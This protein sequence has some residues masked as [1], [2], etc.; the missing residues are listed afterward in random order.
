MIERIIA[1]DVGGTNIKYGIVAG[2]VVQTFS[3]EPTYPE[4]GKDQLL[5]KLKGI[6]KKYSKVSA[7]VGLGIAGLVDHERGVV[8]NPPN[9]PGWDEVD[10]KRILESS[11]NVRCFVVNDANAYALGEWQFGSGR[12]FEDVIAITLGTGVGGGI[13]TGGRL[14][15]GAMNF[16]GEIGHMVIDPSGPVCN[17]G[18]RGC[19]EAFLGNGYFSQR[20]RAYFQR[21]GQKLDDYSPHI[22]AELA[23]NGNKSAAFL[24][25]EYGT[26]LGIGLV[27]L[28]HL[29]DPDVI[30][31][32]G[33]ISGAFDLFIDSCLQ[34][35]R[36]RVM[37]F[38]RRKLKIEKASLGSNASLLGAYYF[39]LMEGNVS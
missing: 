13:I 2:G 14:I 23:R 1:I 6:I 33:G 28:I 8:Y 25:Q 34:I 10:V 24:W 3:S 27:N 11:T 29:F 38:E 20:A 16:A 31:L 26:F 5:E 21:Q 36:S 32:G 35:L 7:R 30:V 17:C 9:F 15:L 12:G 22:L 4:A 18:Q 39:A 19:L 37:G